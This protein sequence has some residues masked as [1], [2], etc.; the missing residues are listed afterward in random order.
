MPTLVALPDACVDLIYLDPPFNSKKQYSNPINIPEE[1]AHTLYRDYTEMGVQVVEPAFSD[2]WSMELYLQDAA[3]NIYPNPNWKHQWVTAIAEAYPALHSVLTSAGQAQDEGLQGYL[4]FMAVR[5]LQMRRVLKDTGSLYLHCDPTASHY[6]KAVMDCIFGRDNFRNE[7]VWCYSSTS[8]ASRWYP[9]KHDTIYW[10][11]KGSEWCFNAD[12]IR[13]PYSKPLARHGKTWK[14]GSEEERK[15]LTKRGKIPESWWQIPM[16]NSMAKERTGYPTQKPLALLNRI[17]AAASNLGDVVLD[18][19]AG[20]ATACVAAEQLGRRWLGI[21]IGEEGYRQVVQRMRDTVQLAS[22]DTPLLLEP[23][24]VITRL[25]EL[26]GQQ[27][28]YPMVPPPPA[29]KSGGRTAAPPRVKVEDRTKQWL[30]GVQQGYCIGC[31]ASLPLHILAVDHAIPRAQGGPDEEWNYQL[32]CSYCNPVKGDRLTTQQLWEVNQ[33]SG[34]LTDIER[35]RRLWKAREGERRNQRF[36][37]WPL[38]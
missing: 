10:Y 18:P 29:R 9:R 19:F 14:S 32:L 25:E 4:T 30:F 16:L 3:G 1:Y 36:P 31:A 12:D 26:P 5:L 2:E 34:V 11:S 38:N 27:T 28:D 17:I 15:S 37:G 21:E 20:C 22:K 8:Q 24:R 13:I 33:V 35:V 6:L 23:E 7:I